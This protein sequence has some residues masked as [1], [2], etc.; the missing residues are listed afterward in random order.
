MPSVA[1]LP[2][3]DLAAEFYLTLLDYK[4]CVRR[5][6][7]SEDNL[8]LPEEHNLP[9]ITDGGKEDCGVEITSCLRTHLKWAT[10]GRDTILR[11]DDGS[12][13]FNSAQNRRKHLI[14]RREI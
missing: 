1:S 7:L 4:H 13:L 2:A 9:A 6:A 14:A 8:F 11:T 5:I 3:L 10:D 12:S